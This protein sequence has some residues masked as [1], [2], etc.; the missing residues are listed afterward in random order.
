V[1]GSESKHIE[2]ESWSLQFVWTRVDILKLPCVIF[3]L[4]YE[5]HI[6]RQYPV[7]KDYMV[8]IPWMGHHPDMNSHEG[9][10]L[11]TRIIYTQ[12]TGS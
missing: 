7:L 8:E 10:A 9:I 5:S 1:L 12:I 11:D 6:L 2:L 3:E 4:L